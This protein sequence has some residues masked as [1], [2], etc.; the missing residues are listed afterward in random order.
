MRNE[1]NDEDLKYLKPFFFGLNE[2]CFPY[3]V[4]IMKAVVLQ[5]GTRNYS[6][7]RSKGR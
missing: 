2:A 7:F 5:V 4:P 6:E 3:C 1:E